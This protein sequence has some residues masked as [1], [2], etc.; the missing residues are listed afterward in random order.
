[1]WCRLCW[2]GGGI[3]RGNTVTILQS[4]LNR[5]PFQD[6]R[7]F[8]LTFVPII[9]ST[10]D[11]MSL[12]VILLMCPLRTWQQWAHTGRWID[13]AA[14]D[15]EVFTT[16]ISTLFSPSCPRSAVVCCRCCKEWTKTRTEMCSWTSL[17]L[18][19]SFYRL[20]IIRVTLRLY[21]Q[22]TEIRRIAT[23]YLVPRH[24]E[25]GRDRI[26]SNKRTPTGV[27]PPNSSSYPAQP[28]SHVLNGSQ[29]DSRGTGGGWIETAFILTCW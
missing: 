25:L 24:L 27:P 13:R 9:S 22:G 16:I 7:T 26:N 20:R 10:S 3:R 11:W 14:C 15:H 4:T 18:L 12:S 23:A 8:Y 29:G 21:L 19:Y 5:Y 6:G 28:T 1:M 2:I 17:T